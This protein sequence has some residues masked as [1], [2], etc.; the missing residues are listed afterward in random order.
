MSAKTE[1][2]GGS[3]QGI[4]LLLCENPLPPIAEAIAAAQAEAPH[5]NFYTEAYSAPLRRLIGKQ[6]QGT[7]TAHSHQCRL[8]A[9]PAA[10]F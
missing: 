6:I 8:R 9:H 7:R 2:G 3:F 4:K 1:K 10:T 5:S